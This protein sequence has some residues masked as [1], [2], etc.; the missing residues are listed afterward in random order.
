[1]TIH[2]IKFLL[3]HLTQNKYSG[4]QEVKGILKTSFLK[5]KNNMHLSIFSL[6]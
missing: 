6:P 5:A 1:M 4:L 2:S 3:F